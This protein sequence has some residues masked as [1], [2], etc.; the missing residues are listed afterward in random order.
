MVQCFCHS[1]CWLHHS[2]VEY[3]RPS[4]LSRGFRGEIPPPP[5]PKLWGPQYR[6]NIKCSFQWSI[7][8]TYSSPSL[9]NTLLALYNCRSS[10]D[11]VQ[12]PCP[13]CFLHGCLVRSDH[14][15]CC[16]GLAEVWAGALPLYHLR[17]RCK[18]VPRGAN[19][20]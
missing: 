20:P 5:P 3:P 14:S 4:V 12:S 19:K 18:V 16:V 15:S 11:S 6:L 1:T 13:S 17:V 7:P 9:L 2:R 10:W 8:L